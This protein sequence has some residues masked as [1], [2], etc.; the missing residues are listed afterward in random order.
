[1]ADV[2]IPMMIMTIRSSTRV[3]PF[4]FL[5]VSATMTPPAEKWDLKTVQFPILKIHIEFDNTKRTNPLFCFFI[6]LHS[7][8]TQVQEDLRE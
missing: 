7:K 3:K 2:R 4:L 8:L 6:L 1:M 5:V